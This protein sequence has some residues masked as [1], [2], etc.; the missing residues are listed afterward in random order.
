M[1][2]LLLIAYFYPPLGG[3]GVQRPVKLVKYLRK[4]GWQTDVIT[5]KNIVFHSYDAELAKEDAAN[6]VIRA[7]SLDPMAVLKKL[8]KNKASH[9]DNIYFGT[10]EKIK[11][12]IRNLFPIDEKI[13]WLPAAYKAGKKLI[14]TEKYDAVMATIGPYTN[15]LVAYKLSR[16]FN[17]SLIIDYRDHWTL[18]PHLK[19]QTRFNKIHSKR[20]ESRIL[21]QASV[22]TAIGQTM[23][24]ELI[25]AF[26]EQLESKSKVMFNGFDEE[27]FENIEIKKSEKTVFSYIG[28]F[29]GYRTPEFF[30]KAMENLKKNGK[31][32]NDLQIQFVGNY[33]PE[34]RKYLTVNSVSKQ[35]TILD[36][37][38]HQE[39]LRLLMSCDAVLLFIASSAGGGILTGKIFEYLRSGK[40][41]LAMIPADGEAALL[42]KENAQNFICAMEDVQSIE[43]NLIK[44]YKAVKNQTK[45]DFRQ[46]SELSRE[47]QTRE[48]V[49]FMDQRLWQK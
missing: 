9:S 42:L 39:A 49:E 12:F 38:E 31:L 35:I 43:E 8:T 14:K 10:P 30:I 48:F 36:Q 15:A 2:K 21:G 5:V 45:F 37:V 22:I 29:Y 41:I 13:G 28:N 6:S 4:F 17:L 16:K 7:A 32:P 25:E 11:K 40:P 18:N 23:Q 20:W 1:K 3:P 34:S 26:G 47:N 44:I 24:N 33:Y 46:P 19:G 27:D